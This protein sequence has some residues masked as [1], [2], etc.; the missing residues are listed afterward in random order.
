MPHKVEN[1]INVNP[2]IY[3][4]QAF[5]AKFR[6]DRNVLGFSDIFYGQKKIV[7]KKIFEIETPPNMSM[8]SGTITHEL[9]E[10]KPV[11]TKIVDFINKK[12][13]IKGEPVSDIKTEKYKEILPGQMLRIHADILTPHYVIEE[14]T[15][16]MPVRQWSR[17]VVIQYLQQLNGYVCEYERKFGVLLMVNKNFFTYKGNDW[18][19]LMNNYCYCLKFEP[20]IEAYKYA[21]KLTKMLFECIT[22]EEYQHLPC[23]VAGSWECNY[24]YHEVME[25]CGKEVFKCQVKKERGNK[26]VK[27]Y[28]KMVEYSKKL[29]DAFI[30]N[31]QCEAC[32]EKHNPRSKYIKFKYRNYKE[33]EK[34]E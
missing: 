27:C 14:K 20:D 28:N 10:H 22:K 33:M 17:E 26:M 3:M 29:T 11:R 30:D 21:L 7:I 31:V 24:C 32:F 25:K 5:Q 6:T 9:I 18:D 8:L 34:N 1:N 2:F 15:T 19:Y 16:V 13:G 23:P 12:Y 4:N